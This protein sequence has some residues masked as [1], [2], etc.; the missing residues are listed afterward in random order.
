MPNAIEH[1]WL[2]KKRYWVELLR[3]LSASQIDAEYTISAPVAN[4]ANVIKTTAG[5]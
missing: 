5:S 1:R 4:S 2:N 3:G